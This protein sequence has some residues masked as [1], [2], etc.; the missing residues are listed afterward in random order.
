MKWR[1]QRN[2]SIYINDA[3]QS[4]FEAYLLLNNKPIAK[5]LKEKTCK[6]LRKYGYSTNCIKEYSKFDDEISWIFNPDLAEDKFTKRQNLKNFYAR[7]CET[8]ISNFKIHFESNQYKIL[9]DKKI[10]NI[11]YFYDKENLNKGMD[12]LIDFK[13]KENKTIH[14]EKIKVGKN[15][16]TLFLQNNEAKI[17]KDKESYFSIYFDKIIQKLKP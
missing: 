12:L 3:I 10:S 6:I 15:N 5:G 16:V 4:F 14:I 8:L 1:Y 7:R 2:D 17:I 11:E 9:N 13:D